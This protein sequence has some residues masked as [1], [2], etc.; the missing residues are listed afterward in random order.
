MV[1]IFIFTFG[2]VLF[3]FCFCIEKCYIKGRYLWNVIQIYA[4]YGK[5]TLTMGVH[6]CIVFG[7]VDYLIEILCYE[8]H[9][10]LMDTKLLSV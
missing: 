3:F 4:K 1:I 8:Q 7:I 5:E 6:Y 10:G 9:L 2:F